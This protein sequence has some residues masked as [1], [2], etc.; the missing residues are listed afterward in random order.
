MKTI[1]QKSGVD[2]FKSDYLMGFDLADEHPIFRAKPQLILT[3]DMIHKFMFATSDIEK[4]LRYLAVLN[5]S[6]LVQFEY[7]ADPSLRTMESS[8]H[9]MMFLVQWVRF[10]E[11]KLAGQVSFPQYVIRKDN[12]DLGN[13]RIWL[14]SLEDLKVKIGNKDLLRDKNAA[15]LQ[16]E[17]EIKRE[18]TIAGSVGSAFT[19]NLA[20]WALDLCNITF[21]SPNYSKWMKMLCTKTS[22]SWIYQI[23]DLYEIRDLLQENLPML[24][25][26]PQAIS[27]MYQMNML[28]RENRRGFTEFSIFDDTGEDSVSDFEIMEDGTQKATVHKIN[29]HFRDVPTSEPMM[30]DFPKKIDYLMAKAKWDLSQKRKPPPEELTEASV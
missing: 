20:K 6:Y 4:K 7:P 9:K 17:L 25:D 2:L 5:C 12:A 11:Y 28:I 26:N 30:K 8:F 27:V 22:E 24:E 1:C 10:A 23:E 14:N 29:Q 16:R 13:I 21:H 19:P 18:L 3:P 15:L